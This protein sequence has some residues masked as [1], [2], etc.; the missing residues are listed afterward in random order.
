[1]NYLKD[2]AIVLVALVVYDMV[3]KGLLKKKDAAE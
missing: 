1:M 3:V 2:V